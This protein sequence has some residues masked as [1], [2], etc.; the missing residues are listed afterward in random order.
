MEN[1]IKKKV[2]RIG[3][4]GQIVSIVLIVLMAVAC[5]GCLTGGILLAILPDDAATVGVSTDLD[6]QVGKS[7]IGRW[8]NEI[9]DDPKDLN[10]QLSVNGSE[11]T[12]MQMEKTADGLLINASTERW[13]FQL[14][15]LASAPFTGLIYCATLLVV[16]IF[17]KRLSDSFRHCDT[18]FS[19]DVIHRMTVF[20]WVLLIGSVVSSA[21]EAVVNSLIHRS[22]DLSFSLNP[23]GMNTGFEVSFSFAPIIIALIVLFLTMIFRYGAQLQKEADETL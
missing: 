15:K 7:I 21:A 13:E 10:A 2:N 17:L 11:F 9:P 23:S 5:F 4:V 16:F 14:N 6:V 8:M 22:L 1:N 19:D 18:P 20:S 12:D 3:L